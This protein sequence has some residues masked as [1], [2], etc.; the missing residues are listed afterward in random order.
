VLPLE[1]WTV[2]PSSSS[3]ARLRLS[4]AQ[5]SKDVSTTSTPARSAYDAFPHSPRS[6]SPSKRNARPIL[7]GAH[8]AILSQRNLPTPVGQFGFLERPLVDLERVNTPTLRPEHETSIPSDSLTQ[9][10]QTPHA[11]KR[12]AQQLRWETEVLPMLVRPYMDYLRRSLNLSQDIELTD[13]N[14]CTCMNARERHLE[15]V[16]LQFTSECPIDFF[17]DDT[18]N[19]YRTPETQHT[20]MSM[21]SGTTAARQSRIVQ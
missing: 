17:Q 14:Q 8:G 9:V 10:A 3:M 16:V 4:K 7:H 15:I 19:I 20:C 18:D 1:Q 11:R 2:Y 6:K 21:L 13:E 12:L 5:L